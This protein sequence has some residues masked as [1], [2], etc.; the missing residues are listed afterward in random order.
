MPTTSIQK[1][2]M[3][4][5]PF[6]EGFC[7]NNANKCK[8]TQDLV[9]YYHRACFPPTKSTWIKYIKNSFFK[10]CPGLPTKL[11]TKYL[12]KYIFAAKDHLCQS[13]KGTSSTKQDFLITSS[14]PEETWQSPEY[15]HNIKTD[16]FRHEHGSK[17]EN[18]FLKLYNA[19][20]KSYSYQTGHFLITSNR[21]NKYVM[22]LY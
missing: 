22:I 17:T 4:E 10:T 9:L 21:G 14:S 8:S 1:K 15:T 7:A 11:V 12:P 20:E 6:L 2:R 5:I 13:Y 19:S 3:T 16:D 18:I